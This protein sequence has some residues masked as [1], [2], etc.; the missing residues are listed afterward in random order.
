MTAIACVSDN[1]P[2]SLINLSADCTCPDSLSG[3][4]LRL[5]HY[6]QPLKEQTV[7]LAA[8]EKGACHV[9]AVACQDQAH[10]DQHQLV[11]LQ[12]SA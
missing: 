2:G 10:V 8:K 11:F 3:S 1:L 5:T 9:R 6:P 4:K 7:W 12:Y